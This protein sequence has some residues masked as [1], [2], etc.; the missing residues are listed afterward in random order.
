MC[1]V[2]VYT[3]KIQEFLPH[4]VYAKHVKNS[5]DS[6]K[7]S[8]VREKTVYSIFFLGKIEKLINKNSQLIF[9]WHL[10]TW[11]SCVAKND[12][13]FMKVLH[14]NLLLLFFFKLRGHC[15]ASRHKHD[16]IGFC[17]KKCVQENEA[18]TICLQCVKRAAKSHWWERGN[19]WIIMFSRVLFF[20][21]FNWIHLDS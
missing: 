1:D 11:K 20:R 4:G 2:F 7:T 14:D 17:N 16:I 18:M 6:T 15:I 9:L 8:I 12:S 13:P 10:I 21:Y 3:F 5:L 19:S